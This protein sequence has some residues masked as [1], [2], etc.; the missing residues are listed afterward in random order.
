MLYAVIILSSPS[1]VNQSNCR[2][3]PRVHDDRRVISDFN[4]GKSSHGSRVI[5]R[6]YKYRGTFIFTFFRTNTLESKEPYANKLV[7]LLSVCST[8][9]FS[10][11]CHFRLVFQRRPLVTFIKFSIIH[12]EDFFFFFN[13]YMNSVFPQNEVHFSNFSRL[14]LKVLLR[15]L[16]IVFLNKLPSPLQL[17]LSN[18]SDDNYR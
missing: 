17:S 3:F 10:V 6:M 13:I 8:R 14:P 2:Y 9:T 11:K 4:L 15:Y 5:K 7:L 16:K 12:T 18:R 1:I